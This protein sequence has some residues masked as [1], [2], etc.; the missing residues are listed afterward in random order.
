MKIEVSPIERMEMVLLVEIHMGR[1]KGEGFC[2]MYNLLISKRHYQD[3]GRRSL[4]YAISL[5]GDAKM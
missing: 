3:Q 1:I 2:F 5:I 4:L